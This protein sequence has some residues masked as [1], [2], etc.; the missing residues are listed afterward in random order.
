M[1]AESH[2]AP[3]VAT[4][5][6]DLFS[7]YIFIFFLLS[8]L[9]S[10]LFKSEGHVQLTIVIDGILI[11]LVIVQNAHAPEPNLSFHGHILILGLYV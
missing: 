11:P 2:V 9:D 8:L 5:T 4:L 1:P 10:R 3:A 7:F 6:Y